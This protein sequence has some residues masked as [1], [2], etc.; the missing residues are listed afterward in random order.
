MSNF[1]KGYSLISLV[2]GFVALVTLAA[3][4]VSDAAANGGVGDGLAPPELPGEDNLEYPILGSKLSDLASNH[5]AS[6]YNDGDGAASSGSDS[7]A[8]MYRPDGATNQTAFMFALAIT[9]DGDAKPIIAAIEDN[10]GDVRNVFDDYIEAYVPVRALAALAQSDGLTWAREAA[11]PMSLR[12]TVTSGGVATHLADAWH[13]AGIRGQ[14]VKVGVIDTRT[15]ATSRDGFAG[16][17]QVMGSDLP[18]TVIGHCYTD[19]GVPTGNLANCA[20][21]LGGHG[22]DHGT[23]VAEAIMDVAPD[24]SLYIANPLTWGELRNSTEWMRSQGVQVIVHSVAWTYHGGAD[25]TSPFHF[26][27]LNTVRWAAN[28][29]MVW[30]NGAG[31]S[32]ED[33]WYGAFTDADNDN[34]HEW[35]GTNEYQTQAMAAGDNLTA[36]MRWDDSWVSASKDLSLLWVKNPGTPFEQVVAEF[37]D[38]QS[39]GTDQYPFEGG[40]FTALTPGNYAIKVKKVRGTT[41]SWLQLVVWRGNLPIHTSGHSVL[42]PADSPHPGMLAVGAASTGSGPIHAYSSRGPT[43]D[44]RIK[45]DIVGASGYAA[46]R[47]SSF[48]GT[49]ASGP[50]VAGLAALVIQQN[51]GYTPHQVTSYLKSQAIPRI[52][53]APNHNVPNNVWG[54]GFARLPALSCAD[55]LNGSGSTSGTWTDSC[56]AVIDSTRYNRYYTITVPQ[57]ATVTIDLQS[58]VDAYLYLRKGYNAQSGAALHEDDN[59]GGGTNA[60]ISESLAAGKYTIEATAASTGQ[61]G[62]FTLNVAGLKTIYDVSITAGANVTEGSDATFM[63]TASPAPTAPLDVSV[64]IS[65]S[66][67]FVASSGTQTVTIPTSGSATL[68]VPT[69]GDSVGE[70]DGSV[71]AELIDS[72]AYVPSTTARQAKVAVS[73]DDRPTISVTADGAIVE[74]ED[75]WFTLSGTRQTAVAAID[76]TVSQTGDFLAPTQTTTLVAA[77]D[78]NGAGK[79]KISTSNDH[80]VEPNGTIT[81]TLSSGTGYELSPTDSSAALTVSDNDV[82]YCTEELTKDVTTSDAW[83]NDC[84]SRINFNKRSR[85]YTFNLAQQSA[86]TVDLQSMMD[87][88]LYLRQGNQTKTGAALHQD[89]NSGNG[90]DAQI[91]ETLQAGWYTIEAT[92]ASLHQTGGFT[93]AISG[94]LVT[95][96]AVGPE[97]SIASGGDVTEGG[98]AMFVLSANPAPTADLPVSVAV[99]QSGD[100]GAAPGSQT[101]TIPTT[102]SYTLTVATSNDNVGEADGSVTVTIHTGAD[103]TV[104]ATAGAATVAVADDDGSSCTKQLSA[105]GATNGTWTTNC[106]STERQG[107]YAR[108]FTFSLSRPSTVTID[109]KSAHIDNYLYLR[110]GNDVK[111]GTYLHEDDDGGAKY[112]NARISES[113]SAGWYTIEATTYYDQHTGNFTLDIS[114]LTAPA[115]VPEVSITA[116]TGITEGGNAMFTVTANPAPASALSVSVSVNQSGDFGV[117]PG[118]QTVSIPTT[119]SYTLAVA[120]VNDGVDEANGSVTATVNNGTGYTVSATAG[121]ATVVVA[122]DDVPEISVSAGSGITEGNNASFTLT[123]SPAPHA[124]LSVSVSVNQSGDFGVSPGSQTVSIPT[125]GSYTLTVATSDDSVDEAD[126]SVAVTVN[127]GNG[128]TVSATAG[129]ASVAV[130]DDDDPPQACTPNLPSDAV[131]VSEVKTWRGEYSQDSHV[132]RWNRVLAALG[133]D[134]GETAMTAD[135]AREIKSR[136]DNTRWDRTVRT[137]EAL[138]QCSNPPTA[139]PEISITGGSGITEGGNATFTVTANPAPTAALSVSVSIAQ[140]GDYGASTGSQTVSIPTSGSYTLTVATVNDAVDETDGSVTAT[141]NSGTGYTVSGTAGSATVV[142]VDDDVPEVSVSAGSG[143]TEGNNATFTLTASP[144]PHA[145]LSVSVSVAQSGDFGVAAGPQTV[146]IPTTGS[147]TLTV[148]TSDDS[149]DEADGL[150]T[151]TV[152]SGTGYTV[153]ATAGAATVAVADDDDAAP[154]TCTPNLP[155]DAITVSEVKT[156]RGEYSQ[157]SHVSR[158]NRVLAALGEDTGEAAMTADQARDI[159]SRIDNTRW[160][161]TARTLEALEQCSNPPTATPE[162]SITAGSG[163][164][165][166]GNASFTITANPAPASALSVSVA[167]SQSGDYGVSSGSQTVSI[168]TGGSATLTVA[169]SDDGVDEADGSVTATVSSGTGYTVSATAGSATVAVADDD[170]PEISVV[171]N[172]D[173]TEGGNATF[174]IS[175]NPAP[176]SALSVSVS[177]SQAGDYGVSAG[178][179]TVSIPTSG[180]ATLTVATSDD[181]VDEAD[182]SVTAT[183]NSG[184]GYTVSGTAG[185]ATVAVAD[186][187]DPP[188]TCT[189][190]LP[191]DAVTVSEVKT[192]RGE[193]SHDDHVSRWNR[194]LAALGEDTGEAAM[195]ADQAREIKSRIDNSRWDRTVRTL[196]ALEQCNNPPP[197]T[198]EVS[199]TAGSGI[200]EGGNATFTLSASPTPS[201]ALSVSVSVAQTGD[202]GATTGSQTV[203]IPTSGSATLTVAT[204]DDGVDEADGSVTATVS[205][206]T[207][208]TVSATAGS[209]TVAVADNDVPEISIAAGS[210]ITEGG[211]ASFTVT[212]SPAPHAPLDVSVSVSQSGDFGVAAGPQTVTIPT[213]GSATLTVATG[214]DS[215]DEA[216]GSVTATVSA[217]QGYTVSGTAGSATV[218]VAD[219]DDAAPPAMPEISITAGNGITEGGNATFTLTASPAPSSALS[220]SVSVAQTGDFGVSTGSQTVSIPTSGSYTLTVAT[221]NDGVDEADGSVTATVSAG[222][223]YTVSTT[224]GAATVAVADDDVPEISITAGTGITE[225]GDASF[226]LTANPAP[227][228]PLSVSV[229]VS[230]SGDFGVTP[231]SQT[232]S[233]PTT[234]S[235]SLT[236]ATSDDGVDEADGSVTATVDSGQGYTVSSTAGTATVAVADDDDPPPPDATPSLSVS[237]AS[238]REDAGVM[239]FTV[240]LSAASDKKVQVHAATTSFRYKTA[241][242]GDDFEWTQVLLTFAPGETSKVVQVVILDDDL[243]EGDESFGMFLAYSPSDTPIAREHGEGVIIDDD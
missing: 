98:N 195:T 203:S 227:H 135:Q 126:G 20:N 21:L 213:T 23:V 116:G 9:F 179:Q 240:S 232:V 217:G 90:N 169:T 207:G 192:W 156:W 209:A 44:G 18:W 164:T 69:V 136:I 141:V 117:S 226:T 199:I 107:S 181:G 1:R 14:G 35:S 91:S 86:V 166:G 124:P 83:E 185:S 157:D 96:P 161:R 13:D 196:E 105:D 142:V 131:T 225:G 152:S 120:T 202:F 39:G 133:E 146:S 53:A 46:S 72:L 216:D 41:P 97:V 121:S 212:A 128:Y 38:T 50:H 113:L 224:A 129:S 145:P 230:Q 235:A 8:S 184:A 205:S 58:S 84:R 85:Y 171:S 132:S 187:D 173:I 137:L 27:P 24:A 16:M 149:V 208:Y 114:G 150:V 77:L 200:T 218:A 42:S 180:S 87:S 4:L 40:K 223:G 139:T 93:L 119:G 165:E 238:A 175:A 75:A 125:T 206:G 122:D 47:R 172:G 2:M 228:S 138:E 78:S 5:R 103:Y 177:V 82:D 73:D 22:D 10:G 30:V 143:I 162:I 108:Y 214:D 33:T 229:S 111:S 49:S 52:S 140:T 242:I 110:Q 170:V 115:A 59:S 6:Q 174:T 153:S 104:S 222:Q 26:G 243:S 188:Q 48:R 11:Q 65:Q 123:A 92:T 210:G 233:I 118:S 7:A 60:Q 239:E 64:R 79:F 231:G 63:L 159:K 17:I 100:F 55:N 168:P 112:R 237:D 220:V 68:A 34:V 106:T 57:S 176:A 221:V 178:S 51:P 158:W 197:A 3:L 80:V 15:T 147:A 204:S 62:D 19:L 130:A 167:I 99:T 191:S 76:V 189:P 127:T 160:D 163:I 70:P 54:Y 241:T 219:D 134:T 109:L 43:P 190:N 215:V 151:A 183:V 32:N 198:P 66:G 88:Y 25:G 95:Q 31:N 89:D 71:T 74:G 12:G 154:Q 193:Y 186:D 194:V 81:V 56:K 67:A 148:A 155:S 201:S 102:G 94:L 236:V 234:G 101:V 211:N 144:A 29:G 182:G 28:N 45:P 36:F 61:T 37:N